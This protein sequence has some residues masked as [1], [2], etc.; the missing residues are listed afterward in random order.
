MDY[1]FLN[2]YRIFAKQTR[3]EKGHCRLSIRFCF[4]QIRAISRKL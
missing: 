3:I 4:A 1:N 2:I